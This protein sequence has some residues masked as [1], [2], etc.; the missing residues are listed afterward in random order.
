LDFASG[1]VDGFV[2]GELLD[3]ASRAAGGF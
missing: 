1:D 3:F 2:A